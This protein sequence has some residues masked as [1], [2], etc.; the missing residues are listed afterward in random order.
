MNRFARTPFGANRVSHMKRLLAYASL[1][2]MTIVPAAVFADDV[3]ASLQCSDTKK[4]DCVRGDVLILDGAALGLTDCPFVQAQNRYNCNSAKTGD[5]VFRDA[6]AKAAMLLTQAG[7]KTRWD[8]AAIF[9]ADFTIRTNEAVLFMRT[10][11]S[12]DASPTM[13]VNQIDKIGLPLVPYQQ[14]TPWVGYVT[15][16]NT[17]EFGLFKQPLYDPP[18]GTG[19]RS[20]P[21]PNP[22]GVPGLSEN[23]RNTA[24]SGV[25]LCYEGRYNG[26]QVLAQATATMYGP[27][28]LSKLPPKPGE[29]MG[30]MGGSSTPDG[31]IEDGGTAA[32]A[33]P[34]DIFEL[35][36]IPTAKKVMGEVRAWNAFLDIGGSLMAGNNW[37]EI[38]NRTAQTSA[39]TQHWAA[40]PPYQG[41]QILRFQPLDLY[42]LGLVP[43]DDKFVPPVDRYLFNITDLIWPLNTSSGKFDQNIGP[44]MGLK[45]NGD[46]I[47]FSYQR[48]ADPKVTIKSVVDAMGGERSPR[49]SDPANLHAH[50]QLWIAI[51]KPQDPVSDVAVVNER[52]IG[53]L[54]KWRRAWS[55]YWYML[56]SYRGRMLTSFD[57]KPVDDSPYWEFGNKDDDTRDWSNEGLQRLEFTDPD[58][59]DPTTP[60]VSTRVIVD[61]DG[62]GQMKY[63]P[64]RLPLRIITDQGYAGANNVA[65][66]RMRVPT[67][68][69]KDAAAF[70]RLGDVEVRVPASV[71]NDPKKEAFLVPDGLWHNYNVDLSK[72]P[73][74]ASSYDSVALRPSDKE[75]TDLEIEYIRFKHLGELELQ[76]AD[77]KCDGT[78]G[79]DGWVAAEDNC[80]LHY[81]PTQQDL[82]A[83]GIGD[84]CQDYDADNI[85]DSCDNC[86]T[87]TNARQ[88]D[89][90]NDKL[91][92]VCDEGTDPGCFLM[93]DSLGGRVQPR[94]AVPL[95]LGVSAVVGTLIMRR[96]R[97]R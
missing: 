97:R 37:T 46:V 31:G 57:E 40:S 78:Q 80:P 76:D 33:L 38:G 10:G 88:R 16:G 9:T 32:P 12:P 85:I 34:T 42:V 4:T 67:N 47:F 83:N 28:L 69:P 48:N 13:A 58:R 68:G 36:T 71:S 74:L 64:A 59:L 29:M 79:S 43:A 92:D 65:V 23:Y 1:A 15:A 25:G 14:N 82:D 55:A 22:E 7:V 44:Q 61:T 6:A 81:N 89:R 72:V 73:D 62:S 17:S 50:R 51:A 49:F 87:K 75:V 52:H 39:A 84:A 41:R 3:P 35:S 53:R 11:G 27:R 26:Y 18:V 77:Q 70:L 2:S 45:G 56:T 96:R 66:I 54:I 91:G 95:L 93:P 90:D 86:P 24:C 94:A 30:G 8:T 21:E 19:Y 63:N 5:V 60:I 20:W